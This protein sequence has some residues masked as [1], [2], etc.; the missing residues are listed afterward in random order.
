MPPRYNPG[1]KWEGF[2]EGK[3]TFWETG[4]TWLSEKGGLYMTHLLRGLLCCSTPCRG[5]LMGR[6]CP[7]RLRST[8]K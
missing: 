6:I 4:V 2:N 8:C 5:P 7:L 3:E 1:A